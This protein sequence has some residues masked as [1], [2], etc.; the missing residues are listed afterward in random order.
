[1]ENFLRGHAGAFAAWNGVPRVL[2]YD[3]LKSV[4]ERQGEAIRFNPVLIDFAKHHRFEPRPVAVAVA[5]KRG[6]S[7]AP[8]AMSAT[9][10]LPLAVSPI[11]TI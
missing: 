8:S 6:V 11:S 10:S 7:S 5:M 3:N 9:T 2:L 1:M 4:L